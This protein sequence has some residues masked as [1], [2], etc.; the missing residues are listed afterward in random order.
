M[1]NLPDLNPAEI[2]IIAFWNALDHWNGNGEQSINP[3][4]CISFFDEYEVYDNGIQGWKS[5]VSGR[6]FNARV[7]TDGWMVA[8]IDRTNTFAYPSKPADEFGENAHKGYYDIIYDWMTSSL[9]TYTTLQYIIDALYNRL[10]NKSSFTFSKDDVGHY[11]YEF[12]DANIITI[13]GISGTV[14]RTGY[15][16]YTPETTL[17]Y[18]SI[19]CGTNAHI[20]GGAYIKFAGNTLISSPSQPKYFY[21]TADIL[22]ENWMPNPSVDYSLSCKQMY[23]VAAIILLWA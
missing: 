15:I 20:Y 19:A 1:A 22:A 13:T 14:T 9:Y 6:H 3:T 11:C 4:D 8:W 10:S 2:G 7:K 18:V 21:A 5:L 16:Q 12:P 17:Y 23:A